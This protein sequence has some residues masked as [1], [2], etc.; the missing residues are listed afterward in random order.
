M[1]LKTGYLD[2]EA[3][4]LDEALAIVRAAKAPVSVGLLG[5]AADL[6]PE[7]VMRG[8]HPDVVT[9]PTSA[10]DPANAYL[11]Q[12]CSLDRWFTER[13][14]DPAPVAAA[15]KESMAVPDH[16]MPGFPHP[17]VPTIASGARAMSL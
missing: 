2:R 5:N 6:Y 4:D 16:A 1:R 14:R 3:R 11:P 10:H 7:L 15:A 17:G 12:G 9:D 13:E 8:V